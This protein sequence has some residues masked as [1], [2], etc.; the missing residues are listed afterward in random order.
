[1]KKIMSIG[2]VFYI[3]IS[4]L[5]TPFQ[6]QASGV[7]EMSTGG[8]ISKITYSQNNNIEEIVY[9]HNKDYKTV[10]YSAKEL[11]RIID[12]VLK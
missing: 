1:M 3:I 2:L 9:F 6:S 8:S 7:L 10:S 5:I 12:Y 11:L 4:I